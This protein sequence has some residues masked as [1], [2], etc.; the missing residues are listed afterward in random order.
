[1]VVILYNLSWYKIILV[2]KVLDKPIN[3]LLC[4]IYIYLNHNNDKK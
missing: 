1:M 4:C 3:I 2:Y